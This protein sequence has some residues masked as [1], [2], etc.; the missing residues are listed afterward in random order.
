MLR[1][2][3][4][5]DRP[6][7]M[8]RTISRGDACLDDFADAIRR[9]PLLE[10]RISL[11][12]RDGS[13]LHRLSV[14]GQAIGSADFILPPIP[15]ADRARLVVEHGEA[16]AQFFR[17]LFSELGH[18]VLLHEREYTRLDRRERWMQPEHGPPLV[19]A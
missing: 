8:P 1:R 2:R 3:R 4:E 18:A 10:Q 13:V 12:Q 16:R 7:A 6:T 11:A 17:Q 19:L 15:A 14:D 5:A 9:H